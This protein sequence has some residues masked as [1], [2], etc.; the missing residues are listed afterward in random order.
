M[1]DANPSAIDAARFVGVS[2]TRGDVKAL[3]DVT[4]TIPGR[5]TTAI[6]GASGSGKSTL[7]QLAIGLLV[8]DTGT[9]DV[10]GQPIRYEDLAPMR[11]R[12][13]YAIQDVALFPHLRIRDNI[14]LPAVLGAWQQAAI[15]ERVEELVALMALPRDVLD[16]YPHELSGGQQQRAGLCRAMMLRPEI[17]LLDEPFSGLDAM[18]RQSIHERFL[19]LQ[20]AEPISSILVTH[21]PQEAINLAD[22][23]AVMRDGRLLQRG[24]VQ[25]IID[26]PADDYVRKLCTGLGE[27]ER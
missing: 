7:V 5:K 11:R 16:R 14:T 8:P 17:L 19:G 3:D 12:M 20:A 21:D 22:F 13:G 4:L 25:A 6:L 9:I 2:L 18:T 10:L 1:S 23:I 15:D 24:P 26:D 27:I